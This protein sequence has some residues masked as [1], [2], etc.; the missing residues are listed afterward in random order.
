M[1]HSLKKPFP[2]TIIHIGP[3]FMIQISAVN[4]EKS[5]ILMWQDEACVKEIF[6]AAGKFLRNGK[7]SGVSELYW[8]MM[9]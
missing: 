4:V 3:E 9:R 1:F 7:I 8:L 2:G 6:A 5:S